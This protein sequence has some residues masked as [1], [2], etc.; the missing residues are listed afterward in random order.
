MK[1]LDEEYRIIL[2]IAFIVKLTKLSQIN[3][4]IEEVVAIIVKK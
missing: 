2:S 1:I 4:P 3:I